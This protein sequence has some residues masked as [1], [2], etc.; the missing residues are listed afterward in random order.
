MKL[1]A[2][3]DNNWAIGLKGDLLVRIPADQKYFREQTMG[4]VIVM[5]RK[6]LESFPGGQPL[7]GR[8]NIVIT[9]NRDYHVK[10]A[11]T[12][13]SFDELNNLISDVDTDEIYII[14]GG[15]IYSALMDWCDTALITKIDREFEADTFIP[16]LEKDPSWELISE[17]EEQTYFDLIYH[18]QTY[19]RNG[20]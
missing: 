4:H 5:G 12:V 13:C 19:K 10:G 14:G 11:E 18:F 20:K 6:T 8:R 9:H 15:S 16:S 3:V 1:I 2:A 17:S 7:A